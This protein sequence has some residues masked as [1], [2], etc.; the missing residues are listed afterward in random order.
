MSYIYINN[1]NKLYKKAFLV[2]INNN[3]DNHKI[4]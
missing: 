4:L 2:T 3:D 1:M